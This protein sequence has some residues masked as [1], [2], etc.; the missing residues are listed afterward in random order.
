MGEI[1][2]PSLLGGG[3][4]G[5]RSNERHKVRGREEASRVAVSTQ[6]IF[7]HFAESSSSDEKKVLTVSESHFGEGYK[8]RDKLQ[9]PGGCF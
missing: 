4:V 3:G 7:E 5:P 9:G 1:I 6:E 8:C 2:F